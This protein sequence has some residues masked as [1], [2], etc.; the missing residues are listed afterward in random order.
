MLLEQLSGGHL[1][2]NYLFQ[3]MQQKDNIYFGDASWKYR[4]YA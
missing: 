1:G 2:L 3:Y 4:E